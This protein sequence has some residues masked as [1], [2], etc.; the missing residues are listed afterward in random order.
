VY[1]VVRVGDA[2]Y[3]YYY[4][5]MHAQYV[6]SLWQRPPAQRLVRLAAIILTPDLQRKYIDPYI[7]DLHYEFHEAIQAGRTV[8]AR[9]L[10]FR[11]YV[12]ILWPLLFALGRM[13]L[14]RLSIAN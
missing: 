8:F 5:G 4:C 11:T 1:P 3:R 13:L 14:S 9:F 2:L 6:L 10:V 12:R 7:A